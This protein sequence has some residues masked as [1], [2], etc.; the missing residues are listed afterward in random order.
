MTAPIRP[1]VFR[2]I[3]SHTAGNPTRTVLS[4]VPALE[5]DTML[6]RMHDL[7]ARYDWIRTSLMYE[8][9][10]HSVMSGCLVLE[11]CDPRADVGVLYIEASGHLPMCGHDT[12]GLVTVLL[13][14]GVLP[15]VEPVTNVVL[16]T[17]AGLV[18]TAAEWK[19]GRVTEVSFVSTPSFLYARDVP[20][21][22]PGAGTV[23]VDI[24]WGGNFY[25]IVDAD[26]VGLDLTEPRVGKRILLAETLRDV[27][28]ETVDVVHP[29]LD[30]I[31]GVTHVQF[32]GPPRRADATNLCSVVIRPGG[33]DRSPCGTGT[34]ARTAALVARGRLRMG[35]PLVH[36]SITGETFTSV[37]VEKVQ[38]GAFDGVRSR[39]TGRAYVTGT[40]EWTIDPHDPLRAGFLFT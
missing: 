21:E 7:A 4:G 25:A 2:T 18:E 34:A 29:T 5:G 17:P 15:V 10:G 24:A 11:P 26:S 36:E 13:Q 32:I 38:V 8:P 27:I 37:P 20:V 31:H 40:A 35:E 22:L 6:E 1:H 30:G 39:I 9:R 3:E 33:A 12:I 16:D 28:N 19:D 14:H 23:T